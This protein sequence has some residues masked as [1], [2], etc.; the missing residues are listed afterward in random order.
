MNILPQL[1]DLDLENLA[2]GRITQHTMFVAMKILLEHDIALPVVTSPN[3]HVIPEGCRE[4]A[5]VLNDGMSGAS[6]F[7]RAQQQAEERAVKAAEEA[8]RAER[9]AYRKQFVRGKKFRVIAE[10]SYIHGMV[11]IAPYCQQGF[12]E[13]LA[14]GTIL[15]CAGESMTYGD[16]VPAIKWLRED[17]KPI[18]ND[19]IF[20]NVV[21]GMW[22]GQV[23][24]PGWME[25]VTEEE[26]Q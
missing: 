23:P 10:G 15:T 14:V 21:G 18:C 7:I 20:S 25:P 4:L 11:P 9:L 8:K 16:G 24:E 19:A 1:H 12:S 26:A 6:D 22:G 13:P 17:G 3:A 2:A 5:D